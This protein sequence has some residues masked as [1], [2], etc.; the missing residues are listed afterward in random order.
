MRWQH[1]LISALIVAMP[2]AGR[3]AD[4]GSAGALFLRIGV[5]ARASAMGEAYTAVAEDASSVFWNPGAMAPV[6][7]TKV[8]LAH[9]EYFQTIRLEQAAVT[10]ETE[11][12]TLGFLFTGMFMDDMDRYDVDPSAVPL[13]TFGAYDMS[14]A[15]AYARYI[16]PNTSIGVSL[17]SVYQRID[18]LSATGFAVDAGI[19][20]TSKIRGVKLAA[21]AG[22]LGTPMNFDTEE[23]ALPRYVKVGASYER[24]VASIEGRVLFTFDAMFPN[25]DDWRQHIGAEYSYRRLLALRAGYKAGYDSQGATF[26]F[27]VNY[28]ELSLDY[29]FLPI[30]NDLGD[31][32]RFGLGFN[33]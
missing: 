9:V 11:F 26:G 10:H 23:Y 27:G 17:K 28:R 12:G 20:H 31:N 15:V 13:G 30:G 7:G 14:F 25:D 4:P 1:I 21:V 18:E 2:A 3:A 19:Y 6:L 24:E 33:F 29:A 32:H 8:T 22:N 5:G 16:V